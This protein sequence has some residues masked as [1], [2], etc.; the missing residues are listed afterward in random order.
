MGKNVFR[1][2]LVEVKV[3]MEEEEKEVK[4]KKDEAVEEIRKHLLKVAEALAS[5]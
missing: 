1:I 2:S 4:V 5:V 3:L